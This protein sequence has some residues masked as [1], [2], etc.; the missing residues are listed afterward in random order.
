MLYETVFRWTAK[1]CSSGPQ[2]RAD[3]YWKSQES[4]A[5]IT[6]QAQ[7]SA[8]PGFNSEDNNSVDHHG[9]LCR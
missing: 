3:M 4:V 6:K 1:K 5:I 8:K 9:N 2:G 7:L